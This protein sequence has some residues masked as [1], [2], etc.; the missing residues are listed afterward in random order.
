MFGEHIENVRNWHRLGVRVAGLTH[1]E[2]KLSGA[3]HALQIDASF[4]GYITPSRRA[5]LLG[6]SKG[7]TSFARESLDVMAELNIPCDVAH[8]NDRAFWQVIEHAKGPVCYTH[9]NCY[10]LCPHSRNLTDE[11]MKALAERGGVMGLCFYPGFIDEESPTVDRLAEHFLHGLEIMGPECV[12][13]GT[14]F[15]GIRR[16]LLPVIKSPAHLPELWRALERK[17][18]SRRTL[19]KIASENFLRLLP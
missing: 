13:V 3:A 17:G 19:K 5:T 10:A 6:Q 11:M 1:G 12:A 8:V 18:V 15:D 16:D 9:G 4:F 7:L 2:G 14:D